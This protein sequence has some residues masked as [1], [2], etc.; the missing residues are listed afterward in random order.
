MIN[1]TPA[2]DIFEIVVQINAILGASVIM[3][4]VD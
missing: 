4:T 2:Y 1:I 3:N